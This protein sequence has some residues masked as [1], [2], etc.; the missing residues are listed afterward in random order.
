MSVTLSQCK[1]QRTDVTCIYLLVAVS[2]Q[3]AE[4]CTCC[5]LLICDCC[6][7]DKSM[8]KWSSFNKT[9]LTVQKELSNL[10]YVTKVEKGSFTVAFEQPH[11]YGDKGNWEPVKPARKKEVRKSEPHFSLPHSSPKP[12]VTALPPLPVIPYPNK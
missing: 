11:L 10:S 12:S 3:A 4:F 2:R 9:T 6:R 1:L 8:L 5:S 7:P